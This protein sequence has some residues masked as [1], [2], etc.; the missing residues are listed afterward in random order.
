MVVVIVVDM[1]INI[2]CNMNGIDLNSTAQGTMSAICA[3]FIYNG[4]IKNENNKDDGNKKQ[5]ERFGMVTEKLSA[6]IAD[7][8]SM[9]FYVLQGRTCNAAFQY[10][11]G[12]SENF[13]AT[14]EALRN[15]NQQFL[16]FSFTENR[17]NRYVCREEEHIEIEQDTQTQS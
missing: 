14:L 5:K 3:M 4:L 8:F 11:N 12:R 10:H 1:I 2:V 6:K 16:H 7:F 9:E 13:D 17:V 15:L